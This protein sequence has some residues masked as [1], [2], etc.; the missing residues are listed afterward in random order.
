MY[1]RAQDLL[2]P[3]RSSDFRR[4]W[5]AQILSEVGDWAARIALAVLVFDRT[6]SAGFTALTTA[7]TLLPWLGIGQLLATLG[8]RFPRRRLMIVADLVRAALFACMA[9]PLPVGVL[10]ILAFAAGTVT[11]P[12]EA[13]RSALLP[14]TV[15]ADQYPDALALASATYQL[16]VVTGS[17]VGGGLLALTGAS[18]AL[19]INAATFLVSA[20][21][22]LRLQS[23]R[24]VPTTTGPVGLRPAWRAINGDPYVRRAI[25]LFSSV[26]ACAV[27]PQSLIAVYVAR[28]L[29]GGDGTIGLVAAAIPSGTLVVSALVPVRGHPRHQLRLAASIAL[30]GSALAALLF[31]LDPG[32]PL[33]LL[34]FVAIGVIFASGVPAN[35]VAG[36]R[37]PDEV[38]ASAFGILVGVLQGAAAA[39]ASIGGLLANVIGVEESCVVALVLG[40]AIAAWGIIRPPGALDGEQ[41]ATGLV[42]ADHDPLA[43]GSDNENGTASDVPPASS[44]Q[45]TDSR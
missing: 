33:V 42:D 21:V 25:G 5:T 2:T 7:V 28:E 40:T 22:L 27:V 18:G 38:R 30:A 32:F 8:D 15:P 29:G 16:C 11:P 44:D 10:L 9:L 13:A 3:L 12:F 17:L 45:P 26:A 31:A 34:A 43:T 1:Q 35:A 24:S 14:S 19:L 41:A 20:A 4:L 39:G 23:G 37:L 36:T 6:R